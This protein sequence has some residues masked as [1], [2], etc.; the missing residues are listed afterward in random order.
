MPSHRNPSS[1]PWIWRILSFLFWYAKEF[2]LANLRVT[3]D[4]LRPTRRMKANPAIAAVPAASVSDAE[5]TLISA[6]I[7][8]TPGTLTITISKEHRVLYVHGMF[9]ETRDALAEEI[10]EME[11]RLLRAMRRTPGDLSRPLQ[12]PVIG[13]GNTPA[14]EGGEQP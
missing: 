12:A 3:I 4:V 8:L 2:F 5:W 9:A 6:L 10:Q 14:E 13:A 11:N 1:A 7:T